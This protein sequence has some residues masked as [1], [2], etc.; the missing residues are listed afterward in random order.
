MR[1][2]T[3]RSDERCSVLRPGF[4]HPPLRQVRLKFT[5]RARPVDAEGADTAVAD[6]ATMRFG[7]P[8]HVYDHNTSIR[9][10]PQSRITPTDAMHLHIGPLQ[11]SL[12][13]YK[14]ISRDIVG[15]SNLAVGS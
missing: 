7:Y 13:P 11:T 10:T 14:F 4:V 9:Y 5:E 1:T 6:H 3:C 8:V 2:S 12:C 15:I